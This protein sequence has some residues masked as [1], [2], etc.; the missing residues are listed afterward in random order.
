MALIFWFINIIYMT[1]FRVFKPNYLFKRMLRENR[2]FYYRNKQNFIRL[3]TNAKP[4]L[5]FAQKAL[6]YP[7]EKVEKNLII[8][9]R[10]LKRL[11][12]GESSLKSRK[13]D[14]MLKS[15]RFCK[16]DGSEGA[17][18]DLKKAK[19]SARRSQSASRFLPDVDLDKKECLSDSASRGAK[20]QLSRRKDVR[21]FPNERLKELTSKFRKEAANIKKID[22]R[23]LHLSAKNIANFSSFVFDYFPKFFLLKFWVKNKI[24]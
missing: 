9:E 1:L 2:D 24:I 22:S 20:I 7:L 4:H 6:E 19:Q 8:C 23:N 14:R 5:K 11:L 3:F 10:K 21:F 12:S 17:N 18:A 15:G 16:K 13:L